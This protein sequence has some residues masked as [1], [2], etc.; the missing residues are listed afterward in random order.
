MK[1]YVRATTTDDMLDAFEGK[2]QELTGCDN[3][4]GGTDV[5]DKTVAINDNDYHVMYKD[6]GGGFGLPGAI[7][8][9]GEFKEMWN[10]GYDDDYVMQEY[11][12]FDD[13]WKV[14][15]SDFLVRED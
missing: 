4:E 12:S 9:F 3:I 13:W 6:E 10:A 14:T 15:L 2:L 11:D 1:R 5:T 8:S 7:Y